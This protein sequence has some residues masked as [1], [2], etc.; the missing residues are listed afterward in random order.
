MFLAGL[1]AGFLLMGSISAV[2]FVG[3]LLHIRPKLSH[4]RMRY[5][6]AYGVLSGRQRVG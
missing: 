1:F 6:A 5:R 2:G 3:L 4:E